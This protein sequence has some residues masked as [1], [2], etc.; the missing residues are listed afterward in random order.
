MLIDLLRHSLTSYNEDHRYQGRRDIPLSPAGRAL[1]R[2][3]DF[4]PE[5]V[6]VSPLARARETASILFPASRLI[7]VED[8]QE[9]SF[10]VFEGRTYE[11][12]ARDS[13]YRAWVDS[14]GEVG[15][16]GGESRADFSSRVCRAFSRLVDKALERGEERLTVVAH[17]GTQMAVM[18]RYALPRRGYFEWNAPCGG[19]YVLDTGLWRSRQLLELREEVRYTKD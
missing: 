16:P 11:E 4:S 13:D 3:A 12:M 14:G 5:A 19:G 18:E 8:L 1:L 6:Y 2:P 10:G 7:P 17:G 15:C 9:V